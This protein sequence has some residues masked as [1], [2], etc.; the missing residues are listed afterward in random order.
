MAR[1]TKLSPAL[2]VRI[3]DGLKRGHYL[4][5]AAPLTGLSAR[6]GNPG[7]RKRSGFRVK[8]GMTHFWIPGQA[9]NDTFLDW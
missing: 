1:K 4:K 7:N 9:R 8:P 6:S 2:K 5:T 3:C